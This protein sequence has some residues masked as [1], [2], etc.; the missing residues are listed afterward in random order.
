MSFESGRLALTFDDT[1]G[2]LVSLVHAGHVVASNRTPAG[3]AVTFAFGPTN[4]L[5]WL[6][7]LGSPRRLIGQ[8]R[9]S[10]ARIELT[11][12]A[13]SFEWIERYDIRDG[14]DRLDRSADL[15]W[16]G[17][18]EIAMRSFA[19][20]LRGVRATTNGFYAFPATWPPWQ[21][22]FAEMKEGSKRGGHGSLAAAVAEIA[23]ARS[24]VWASFAGDQPGV[25]LVEGR[26]TFDVRQNLHAAGR[27]RPGVTQHLGFVSTLFVSGGYRDGL[28]RL[29]AWQ[30]DVGLREPA[31]RAAWLGESTVYS[32]HPGGTIGSNW[33][34]LGGF[35]AAERVVPP[36]VQ[37]LNADAVWLLPVE[38]KS[39][40]WP[41]D[42]YR[43][44]EGI[45]GS[46]DY[47]RLVD[48]L[49]AGG[50][51]VLQDIVP[52]GG[53]P[54]AVHNQAHPEFMLRREDGS[55][56]NYWLNDFARPDWQAFM[57][58]VARHYV[59]SY[60]ID[61]YRVDACYGSKEFNWSPDIP[62]ERA[63]LAKLH[64]G[65]GLLAA[66]RGAVKAERPDGALLAEVESERHA[67]HAEATYDF[68][69]GLRVCRDWRNMD[70]ADFVRQ[71]RV[72]LDEQ[73]FVQPRGTARLRFIESHDTT[74]AQGWYGVQGVRALYALS[75]WIDGIPM[76]YQ[77]ME[78]G[79]G[80]AFAEINR[81]RRER[82][83]LRSGAAD[84]R[85]LTCG[86]PA[87]FVASRSVDG[88]AT[89]FAINFG[90]EPVRATLPGGLPGAEISLRPLEYAVLG[91]KANPVRTAS[92]APGATEMLGDVVRFDG[93]TAW[94][95][96]TAEGRLRDVFDPATVVAPAPG[97]SGS[98]YWR[99]QGRGD[100]WQSELAPLHPGRARLGVCGADGNWRGYELE[101]IAVTG[102]LRLCDQSDGR[103]GLTLYGA[104]GLAAR[105]WTAAGL[106]PEPD[107]TLPV[108]FGGVSL[109]VVGTDYIVSNGHFTVVLRRTGG[110]IRELNDAK[111][112][113][114]V[115]R[116][117]FYGDQAFFETHDT[118]RMA[119]SDEGET[120][121][122]IW[123][124]EDGLHLAFVGHLR[125]GYRF[126]LKKPGLI[127]RNEYV[128]G[129]GASF[130]QRWSFAT[131]KAFS[132][133]HAF[134]AFHIAG[135]E[136][137]AFRFA[138]EGRELATGL[139]EP[140]L[141]R[142]G[143]SGT[144]ELPDRILFE[145]AGAPL[146]SLRDIRTPA[147]GGCRIFVA[148]RAPFI[149]LLDGAGASMEAGRDYTFSCVWQVGR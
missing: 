62:Y 41:L 74:R 45:G 82:P 125:D 22:P 72:F 83:E 133:Q 123:R 109:R 40:Y 147:A 75:A 92:V 141:A 119:A 66:I 9:P 100:L 136:G 55:T 84:Y 68:T 57:A 137:D 15:V 108:D 85:T 87:V 145:R 21:R 114:L 3:T 6:E 101:G 118:R 32:F 93:A 112:G 28:Q 24:L 139:L 18:N 4:R 7:Q 102:V 53:A 59:R 71:L 64:G 121:I 26:T 69:F 120:G 124:A 73:G 149:T 54:Q 128:F 94:F 23:P 58:D 70:A 34:D 46:N 48:A 106:P 30:R 2:E 110:V 10:P 134:L 43:F 138:R 103:A 90:R 67:A 107:V 1:G 35:A 38:Y 44:M 89:T 16:R 130:V 131:E 132:N 81:I 115:A 97:G 113:R 129:P 98:I 27:L 36:M 49:H 91:M 37:R 86:H 99:P 8:T 11:I 39:P 104:G 116:Q 61:G 105:T 31:D 76:I 25:D 17:T 77:G 19:F 51:R 122:R 80:P 143:L 127:F 20:F 56:L 50:V 144:G 117:D 95:V 140:G 12:A 111:G 126:A 47:R 13:G 65:L 63:S 146:W 60:G 88:R 142:R 52:H 42:Y 96:D 33:K 29:Q 78:A 5:T 79:H 148:G 135:A 14:G